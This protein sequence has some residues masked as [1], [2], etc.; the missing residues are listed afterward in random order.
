V[1]ASA[2][3]VLLP[4]VLAACSGGTN[5]DAGTGTPTAA[6]STT[7][8]AAS[9]S[10][11][12]SAPAG[13]VITFAPAAQ[14]FSSAAVVTAFIDYRTA[15]FRAIVSV[16]EPAELAATATGK[17]LAHD[18]QVIA[19]G[20]AKGYRLEGRPKWSVIDVRGE[21]TDR[22]EVDACEW[23]SASWTVDRDGKIVEPVSDRW[24]PLRTVV[25]REAGRYRVS[26]SASGTF[27]CRGAG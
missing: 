22:A 16:P 13:P 6:G 27:D 20:K 9:P 23:D 12:A 18:R 26:D 7:T 5:L 17:Q 25:I 4:V 1:C 14:Q 10:L 11:V 19:E 15:R 3:A 24:L 2:V 8:V 21:G